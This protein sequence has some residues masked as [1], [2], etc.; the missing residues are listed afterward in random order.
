MKTH[1]AGARRAEK[2]PEETPDKPLI[3]HFSHLHIYSLSRMTVNE[4]FWDVACIKEATQT[5]I[6]G[7][8]ADDTKRQYLSPWGIAV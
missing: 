6:V 7:L 5:S 2:A 1:L 4:E 3:N 8:S